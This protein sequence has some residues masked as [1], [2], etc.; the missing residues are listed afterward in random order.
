MTELSL[1]IHRA[2]GRSEAHRSAAFKGHPNKNPSKNLLIAN[3]TYIILIQ[4]V[5][6][7]SI[8]IVIIIITNTYLVNT[9][10]VLTHLILLPTLSCKHVIITLISQMRTERLVMPHIAQLGSDRVEGPQ[11]AGSQSL[12][13]T[14]LFD[15]R[16]AKQK[17]L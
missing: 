14:E 8:I 10:P 6:N 12:P 2:L 15:I 9:P 11:T 4:Q 1:T 17:A 3:E 16:A 7:I 5:T 13:S